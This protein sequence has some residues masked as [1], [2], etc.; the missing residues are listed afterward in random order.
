MY[1][2]ASFASE[3]LDR[4]SERMRRGVDFFH[5]LASLSAQQSRDIREKA[6]VGL[7]DQAG[8][9]ARAGTGLTPGLLIRDWID[10]G[11]DSAERAVF[12]FGFAASARQP[13]SGSCRSRMP[14]GFG[15]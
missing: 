14:A 10:Y 6:S 13:V 8:Q 2:P 12:V 3:Q 1:Q 4:M 11:I 7:L 15:V 9:A 5:T